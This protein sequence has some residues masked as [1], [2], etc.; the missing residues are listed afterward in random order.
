MFSV[1]ASPFNSRKRAVYGGWAPNP[2]DTAKAYREFWGGEPEEYV[3][4]VKWADL[5]QKYAYLPADLDRAKLIREA[6]KNVLKTVR[7]KAKQNDQNAL[8]WMA[9]YRKAMKNLRSPFIASRL[10]TDA[11]DK[12]WN[13]FQKLDWSDDFDDSQRLWL[14]MAKNAPY[15]AAPA[16]PAGVNFGTLPGIDTFVT[17]R[18]FSKPSKLSADTR[19]LLALARR[20]L[21]GE[22]DPLASVGLSAP[23][24]APTT[25]VVV[26]TTQGPTVVEVPTQGSSNMTDEQ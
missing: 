5:A 2:Y 8:Y 22:I 19:R 24:T 20:G 23:P 7:A 17:K 1:G 6:A 11:R 14:A 16:L 9:R 18:S 13:A 25:P 21:V 3:Q 26:N 15:G 10:G 12:I 4:D